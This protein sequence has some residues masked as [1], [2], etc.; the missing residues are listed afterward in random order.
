[1]STIIDSVL[2][3]F[4]MILVG[5][6]GS[7]KKIITSEINKGLTDILIQ[8]ALPFM[9]VSSFIFTY[10]DTI[11]TNVVNTFFYSLISYLIM[12]VVSCLLLLPV[13]KDKKTILHFAN[14]FTNT[15]YVGFPIFFHPSN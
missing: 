6:Y 14:V 1:M 8:I 12:A 3:L 5:V 2:S 15:G 4:I 10:D 11:K 9:I 7:N 13:K